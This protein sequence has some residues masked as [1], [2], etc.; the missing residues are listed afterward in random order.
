MIHR[1]SRLYVGPRT[2]K[3]ALAVIVS[4]AVVELYGATTSRMVFA[5]L[6]AMAAVQPTFTESVASSMTQIVGVLF[7]ALMGVALRALPVHH[8]IGVGLGIV[9]VI[10]GYNALHIR[11]SPSLPCLVVVTIVT[12]PDIQPLAYALG[13]VW[14]TAIGL[15]V[16]M[17][18]N[19]L[20]MPYDNSRQIRDSLQ[21][22]DKEVIVFLEEMFDG[23]EIL[24]RAD[25]M[26]G[27]IR[28][29][30]RQ[31][32]IFSDQRLILRLRRQRRQL[33]RFRLCEQK[34]REL[35]ARMEILSHME[36]PGRLDPENRRSLEEAGAKIRDERPLE[37]PRE[38]DIVTNYHVRQILKLRQTL[39][40]VLE[41]ENE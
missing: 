13:R 33:E 36:G 40:E 25:R 8:L 2:W 16:G 15:G 17:T 9:L 22:L 30:E 3:T 37:D 12:T 27:T 34:A 1:P 4:L 23:D 31:L 28:Q 38:R 19:T 41:N 14:D 5:M 11:F 6:G 35:V 10:A 7:G 29:L 20:V 24:P 32:K 39:M 18:I 21:S 26:S